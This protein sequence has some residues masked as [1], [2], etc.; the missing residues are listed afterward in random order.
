MVLEIF[1]TFLLISLLLFVNFFWIQ[2]KKLMKFY[3]NQLKSQ[4]YKSQ[5]HPYKLFNNGIM[6]PIEQGIKE[7][8]PFKILKQE[9]PK[10]D[11]VL[12]NLMNRPYIELCH[13]DFI[14]DFYSVD[15]HYDY[16]KIEA[17]MVPFKRLTG[18]PG[19]GFS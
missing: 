7:G 16:P 4:K 8:N 15:K 17:I 11:V 13:V 1:L 10:Y 6:G 5:I 14:K 12:T 9:Y 2:P 18:G 3:E 19:I